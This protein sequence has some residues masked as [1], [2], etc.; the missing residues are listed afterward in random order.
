MKSTGQV[1]VHDSEDDEDEEPQNTSEKGGRLDGVGARERRVRVR[2]PGAARPRARCRAGGRELVGVRRRCGSPRC[3]A[4]SRPGRPAREL[5]PEEEPRLEGWPTADERE[6][7]GGAPAS[8]EP[9]PEGTEGDWVNLGA[10]LGFWGCIRAWAGG[11]TEIGP[12]WRGSSAGDRIRVKFFDR[13]EY[14]SRPTDKPVP[15][16]TEIS[17]LPVKF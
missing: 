15:D 7:R 13:Y 2:G 16:K 12:D 17:S 11:E 5:Q 9:P 4:R 1:C 6:P 14:L 10:I 8:C 3:P